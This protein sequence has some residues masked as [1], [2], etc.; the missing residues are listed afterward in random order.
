MKLR[1]I[2]FVLPAIAILGGCSGAPTKREGEVREVDQYLRYDQGSVGSMSYF[3][4][5]DGWRPVGRNQLFV[6]DG[7]SNGYLIS[8]APP[9]NELEYTNAIGFTQRV[10]GTVS[11]GIDEVRMSGERCRITDIR[12]IDYK[13]M[14]DDEKKDKE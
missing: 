12:R 4:R 13:K 5:F 6:W 14:R 9:C 11:S 7:L 10:R 2:L 8:V 3:G 1:G